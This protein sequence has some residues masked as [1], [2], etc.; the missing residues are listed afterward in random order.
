MSLL[1]GYWWMVPK[2]PPEF[3]PPAVSR[4]PLATS[5]NS[6]FSSIMCLYMTCLIPVRAKGRLHPSLQNANEYTPHPAEVSLSILM[7]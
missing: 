3:V 6:S 4:N 7:A 2:I 1:M 5:P